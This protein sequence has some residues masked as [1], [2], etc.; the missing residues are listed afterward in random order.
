MN[1]FIIIAILRNIIITVNS[2]HILVMLLYTN[3]QH[4]TNSIIS[5]ASLLK[6]LLTGSRLSLSSF[7]IRFSWY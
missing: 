6:D 1:S 5:I 3:I 7:I 4:D 2:M